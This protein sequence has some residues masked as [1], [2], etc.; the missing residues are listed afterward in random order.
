MAWLGKVGCPDGF[1]TFLPRKKGRQL[2]RA[3]PGRTKALAHRRG[4]MLAIGLLPLLLG[5]CATPNPYLLPGQSSVRDGVYANHTHRLALSFE[6]PKGWEFLTTPGQLS[7]LN[8][9]FMFFAMNA[10]RVMFLGLVVEDAGVEMANEDYQTAHKIQLDPG[11][12][13]TMDELSLGEI[14]VNGDQALVWKYTV[15][16]KDDGDRFRYHFTLAYF[17]RGTQNAVLLIWTQEDFYE[18]RQAEIDAIVRTFD[19]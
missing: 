14:T 15:N 12:R 11:I 19:W 18:R 10:S 9:G 13:E 8:A 4:R 3:E 17:S 1:A 6:N 16:P 2:L 5:A 7:E